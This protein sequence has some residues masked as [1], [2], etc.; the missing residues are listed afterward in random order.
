MYLTRRRNKPDFEHPLLLGFSGKERA[1]KSTA[2]QYVK[3]KHGGVIFA[4]ADTLKAQVFDLNY[5]RGKEMADFLKYANEEKYHDFDFH[6]LP[7][8]NM[9]NPNRQQKIDWINRNKEDFGNILQVY[10][11]FKRKDNPNFFIE[12]TLLAINKAVDDG[13]YVISVDDLRFTN[14]AEAL[15]KI[16][17]DI[18]RVQA[19]DEIRAAR[20]A[21]RNPIHASETQL[22][23]YYHSFAVFNNLQEHDLHKQI[24]TVIE[25]ILN[26]DYQ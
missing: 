23:N 4:F 10:G 22:D 21:S 24:D 26:K 6:A 14:E 3:S 17:F 9:V 19:G 20:G 12:R 8:A 7:R 15:S 1:G 16:G 5:L 13:Q 25:T 2:A 18:V 11:D